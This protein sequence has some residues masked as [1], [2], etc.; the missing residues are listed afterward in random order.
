VSIRS[1]TSAV[2]V[3]SCCALAPGLAG[4]QGQ[5]PPPSQETRPDPAPAVKPATAA[6]LAGR[7][8]VTVQT[9]QGPMDTSLDMKADPKDPKRVTGMSASQ[10]G[11]VPIEGEV[12]DGKLTFWLTI[13]GGG[14]GVA[15]TF[16]GTLQKDGSLAGTFG[17]GEG[18]M[19]WTAVR[20][21][22]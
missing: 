22:G 7:W 16:V 17:Y 11:E 15:I 2:A 8:T 1:F 21:K 19:P 14:G 4:A 6:T 3:L 13:D 10:Y 20:V 9:Q 12:V 5:T 18:E